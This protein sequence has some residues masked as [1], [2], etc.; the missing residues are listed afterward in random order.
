MSREELLSPECWQNFML[1]GRGSLLAEFHAR[2]FRD[3][4]ESARAWLHADQR[5]RDACRVWRYF[6]IDFNIGL[7]V[8]E[9]A[10]LTGCSIWTVYRERSAG[11]AH[12]KRVRDA[13]WKRDLEIYRFADDGFS[14]REIVVETDVPFSTVARVLQERRERRARD[15]VHR[16][17][18][19]GSK[20]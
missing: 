19:L 15:P 10:A 9:M 6:L 17:R 13:R 2:V 5:Y 8:K 11:G 18:F 1:A 16:W 7:S 20:R 3:G 4:L 14:I 12:R